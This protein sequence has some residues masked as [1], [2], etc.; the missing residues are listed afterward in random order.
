VEMYEMRY[1][2]WVV[3]GYLY[4]VVLEAL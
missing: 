1:L 4:W 3:L 2:Y